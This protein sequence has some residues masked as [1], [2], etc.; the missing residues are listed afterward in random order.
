MYYLWIKQRG[1]GC[2]HTIA[3]GQKLVELGAKTR[4]EAVVEASRELE[5][6]H[7]EKVE[8]YDEK[9]AA[10]ALLLVSVLDLNSVL[11]SNTEK[12]RKE[13]L[14]RQR[15]G[16]EAEFERLRKELGK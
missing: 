12:Y 14:D 4:E 9:L 6:W 3:C 1:E 7:H 10:S 15:G 5:I 16:K 13:C 2:D 8:N 11:V